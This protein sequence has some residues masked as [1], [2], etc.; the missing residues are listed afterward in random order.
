M[1]A[2]TLTLSLS[3]SLSL[4][5]ILL[6]QK[7]K[8]ILPFAT[9]WVDLESIMLSDKSDKK[10]QILYDIIYMWNIKIYITN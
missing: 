8:E 6:S 7:K 3:H 2:R 1:R 10:R 4:S 9:T 5:G